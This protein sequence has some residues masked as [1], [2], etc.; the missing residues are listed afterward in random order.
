[1]VNSKKTKA[2]DKTEKV[3]DKVWEFQTQARELLHAQQEA[4]LTAVKSWRKDAAAG[5]PPPWP[6]AAQFEMLP[7]PNEMVEGYYAFA[8]KLLAD[9]SQFM[10]ALSK[11]MTSPEDKT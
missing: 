9:Q 10:E 5:E 2:G 7:T 8:A 11:V 3:G 4:Y 1:M 6:K